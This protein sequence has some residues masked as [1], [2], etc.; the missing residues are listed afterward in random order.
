MLVDS[1]VNLHAEAFA[2]D[3]DAVIERARAAGVARMIAIC[4]RLSEAD[5]VRAV[6]APYDDVFPTLGAHPHHAKDRPGVTADEIAA[7]A[8][9]M[10][11]VAIGETGLDFHYNYSPEPEQRAS[12]AAHV[13]AAR[14]LDLPLVIHCRDADDAMAD[15]LEQLWADGPF[16]FLLHSYTGGVDLA[17]RG[18]AL[19]GYFSVNGI[20]SFKN[21]HDVR[22]VITTEMPED[23]IL[24][25]TDAP[26][27]APPP[28]RGRRNEPAFLP[29]VAESLA[30]IRGWTLA[31]TAERTTAAFHALFDRVP[32]AAARRELKA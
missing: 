6:V 3:R 1:H 18:A 11:A 32:R 14:T 8:R 15:L 22:A 20:A 31:E 12:F 25:E 5:A 17:R 2:P 23:R 19:G 13:A 28:H 30:Q 7:L 4:S 26:Y 10:D 9:E 21:A 16:R 24:L 29:H 27:L